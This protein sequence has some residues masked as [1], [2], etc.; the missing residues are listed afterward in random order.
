MR[1]SSPNV[2]WPRSGTSPERADKRHD[3]EA[4][5]FSIAARSSYVGCGA[6][7]PSHR[8]SVDARPLSSSSRDPPQRGPL[9]LGPLRPLRLSTLAYLGPSRRPDQMTWTPSTTLVCAPPPPTAPRR[10]CRIIAETPFFCPPGHGVEAELPG[11]LSPCTLGVC[12]ATFTPPNPC[13]QPSF[14][15]ATTI[16]PFH[17]SRSRTAS[18]QRAPGRCD[19]PSLRRVHVL[20]SALPRPRRIFADRLCSAT[21]GR[22]VDTVR[23]PHSLAVCAAATSTPPLILQRVVVL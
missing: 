10:R 5:S 9:P 6:A 23:A 19:P 20:D 1:V 4:S 22:G 3:Y 12:A 13:H 11:R 2:P 14:P 8:A 17:G 15:T 16:D 7:S 18:D 21:R